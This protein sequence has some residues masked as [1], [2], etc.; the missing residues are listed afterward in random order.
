MIKGHRT[1]KLVLS[2]LFLSIGMVLPLLTGQIKEIGDSLLPMHLPVMLC[3]VI[4]GGNYGLCIGLILPFLR[5]VIFGMPPIYPNAIWMALELA[6]YGAVIGFLYAKRKHPSR[7]HLFFCL[8]CS[9]LAGR[10][11][12]GITKAILLG[13]AEKPFGI[14]A[15][16]VG[17]F[18][19]A[20]PGLVLQFILI[21]LI[22]E[23]IH[24]TLIKTFAKPKN[25]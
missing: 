13:V 9:M 21:P 17:G 12:W 4:C 23:V 6:T 2:A 7:G 5:S 25:E 1:Q 3:G 11:V 10:I 24:R 14:E 8:A 19:D 15:F 20:I 18:L 22:I 16:L